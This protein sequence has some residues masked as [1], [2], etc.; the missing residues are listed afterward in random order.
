MPRKS[1]M[2]KVS[3]ERWVA[4]NGARLQPG[5]VI[6]ISMSEDP[7]K[8]LDVNDCGAS[9]QETK[10]SVREFTH[11]L[12]GKEVVIHGNGRRYRISSCSDVLVKM[13]TKPVSIP[14][15]EKKVSGVKKSK[16][17]KTSGVNKSK[18]MKCHE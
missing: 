15:P 18:R 2:G 16:K 17:K 8:V 6:R 7:L 14:H 10:E 3:E 9:V 1:L 5:M 12:S 11:R 4:N 13:R